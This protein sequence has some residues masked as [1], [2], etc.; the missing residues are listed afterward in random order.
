LASDA[1]VRRKLQI[2]LDASLTPDSLARVR[3]YVE[4]FLAVLHEET[5]AAA[6]GEAVVHDYRVKVAH[7]QVVAS[8]TAARRSAVSQVLAKRL[9]RASVADD[10]Q[11]GFAMSSDEFY[12]QPLSALLTAAISSAIWISPSPSSSQL[13]HSE[14]GML[15]SAMFTLRT[16]SPTNTDPSASQSP[17]HTGRALGT[18]VGVKPG[19]SWF[20]HSG[21][22]LLQLQRR[23]HSR[24]QFGVS[25]QRTST[26]SW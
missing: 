21:G 18:G 20:G 23:E 3:V 12:G 8:E 9:T 25:G 5:A 7:S 19:S 4:G 2:A 6:G 1:K 15:P 11:R 24:V 10:T 13:R 14:I 16:S 22:A 26:Q 17:T